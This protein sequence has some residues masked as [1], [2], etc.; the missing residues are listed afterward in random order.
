MDKVSIIV[1]VFRE[2]GLLESTL[3][4]FLKDDYPEK[5]II[6]VVDEPTQN[7]MRT[8]K[9]FKKRVKFLINKERIGKSRALNAAA[10]KASGKVLFF[11]DSDN[12]IAGCSR[13]TIRKL[14]EQMG[15][16]DLA[17]PTIDTIKN[18]LLSRLVGIEF[19]NAAFA[20]LLYSKIP[21]EK[22]IIGGAAFLIKSEAFAELGG[23]RNYIAEDLDLTWR[24]Y[25]SN[26]KY[27]QIKSVRVMTKA[28]SNVSEWVVQRNRWVTGTAEWF[29]RDY[30]SILA[31]MFKKSSYITVPSLMLIFPSIVLGLVGL[32]LSESFLEQI[33]LFLAILIPLKIP[34]LTSSLFFLASGITV[35]KSVLM[36]FV[37]F[38]VAFSS[39]YAVSKIMKFR[40]GFAEYIIYYFV[41]SPAFLL[42]FVYGFLKVGVFKNLKLND[43]KV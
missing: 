32:L 33:V 31:N 9:K 14:V 6:V 36:Y 12:K 34:E 5:E 29:F 3:S 19:T 21:K 28:A 25:K 39:T 10:E 37:G 17:E 41:Y 2:S 15:D 38:A 27:R 26:K 30:E 22:P 35:F 18:S 24:A 11:F 20:G 7:S 42:F 40:V 23:F 4:R 16:A 43:W 1:P 8:F 13:G